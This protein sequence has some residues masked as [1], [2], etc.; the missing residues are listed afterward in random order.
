[1]PC[2]IHRDVRP[3]EIQV[4]LKV[5]ASFSIN[6]LA[7]LERCSKRGVPSPQQFK[8]QFFSEDVNEG[9]IQ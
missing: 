3:R 4:L 2:E 7:I 6:L 8:V 9:V 5:V 1:M